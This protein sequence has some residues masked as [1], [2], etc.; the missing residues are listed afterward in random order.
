[1]SSRPNKSNA[2]VRGGPEEILR[3]PRWTVNR[4]FKY[5]VHVLWPPIERVLR[6]PKYDEYEVAFTG[7]SLGGALATIAAARAVKQGLRPG[8]GILVYTFGAPRVGDTTFAVN[9]NRIIPN[10]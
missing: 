2:A 8:N 9:F 7:H 3:S 6:D 1:M 5:G 4:Y 10:W